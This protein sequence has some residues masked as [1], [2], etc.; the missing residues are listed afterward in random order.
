MIKSRN[1]RWA[2]HVAQMEMRNAYRILVGKPDR[3]LGRPR[4]RWVDN[5][6][7]DLRETGQGSMDW[8]DLT[9]D[10][11]VESC[12]EHGNEPLCSTKFWEILE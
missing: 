10:R 1:M 5:I 7:M 11:S 3:P 8:I 2:G 4:C 9:Q 12:C 6:N